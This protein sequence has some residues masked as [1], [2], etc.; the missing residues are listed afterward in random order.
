MN[1]T[2]RDRP[3][4]STQSPPLLAVGLISAAVLGYEILLMRL[5]SI[6]Q[7]HH[8]AYMAISLAL[9]GYGV[10]GTFVSLLRQRLAD[11]YPAAFVINAAL[12][13]LSALVVFSLAQRVPFNAL[14]I[15]WDPRQP[16][17]LL[18]LYLL[19]FVP[20]FFA[21]NCI[22]LTFV[23]HGDKTHRV[24]GADLTGAAG[25]CL[26]VIALLFLLMPIRALQ[27]VS[28]VGLASAAI[29]TLHFRLHARVLLPLLLAGAAAILFALPATMTELRISQYKG[30][31]QALLVDGAQI[32]DQRSSPLGLLTV[33]DS[34][35]VPFRDAPGLSLN[36]VTEPP[37]QLGIFTDGDS[38]SALTRFDGDPSK[39][40]YLDQ[41]TSALPYH[42]LS[43][44]RVLVLGAGAGAEVLQ[45]VQHAAVRIDAVELNPQIV[46]L[47]RRRY[48][49]FAGHLYSRPEVRIHVSEARGFVTASRERYDLIQVALLDPFGASAAGLYGLSESY[50]YTVEGFR[51]DLRHLR[52]DG[53]LAVTRW[54]SLPPR[55]TLKLFATAVA[56]LKADGVA[57][58]SSRLALVRG[59]QTVTLLIK[60]SS[61]NRK[62][63]VAIRSFC[64]ARAFDTAWYPGITAGEVNHF[65]RLDTPWFYRGAVALLGNDFASFISHYKFNI[66]PATDD[67]PYFFNF[68]RWKTLPEILSLKQRGGLPLLELGYPVLVATLVQALLA[69]TV[70]ILLPLW[71]KR[72]QRGQVPRW[73]VFGYF[74]ALG[75]AFMFIEMAFIQKFTLL[76][77]HPLYAVA[78]VL[79]SF[80]LFAGIGSRRAE[81]MN[82]STSR[83]VIGI[84]VLSAVYLVVLPMLFELGATLPDPIKILLSAVLIAPLAYCMGM[85]FPLGMAALAIRNAA[86]VPWAYGINA[87]AS[88]IGATLATVLAIH[89]GFSG[90][91]LLAIAL[92]CLAAAAFPAD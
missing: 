26:L 90:V 52:P 71:L 53:I 27:V 59:W 24:Y 12:F 88:V 77:T 10:S 70:L 11:H 16:L 2:A 47:V 82:G 40:D 8:F 35:R 84:V 31:R 1:P 17:H 56:A 61:F 37:A 57:D 49:D 25:G 66:A 64:K 48:A 73:R 43:A 58:P 44:P 80:L 78:V 46:D 65:N 89:F 69:S 85:P 4:A 34:P 19:L 72:A 23:C 86:G 51:S 30:L 32:I 91:I 81:R 62:D 83:P 76:L 63:I 38:F 14:E 92:Y 74:A 55:D 13:G 28:V 15:F 68:F 9:L 54:V 18:H 39:L 45:A 60:R 50:L 29:A 79:F 42:L 21:A 33:V 22:C 3:P 41:M 7:W 6:I 75:F 5:F 87:C 20:F 36:A 67:R